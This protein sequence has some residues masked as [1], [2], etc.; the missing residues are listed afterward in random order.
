MKQQSTKIHNNPEPIDVY[1]LPRR[2][3]KEDQTHRISIVEVGRTDGSTINASGDKERVFMVVGATGAGKTTLIYIN[4]MAN[5]IYGVRW[6]SDFRFRLVDEDTAH[7]QAK[8]QTTWITAYKFHRE[9]QSPLTYDLMIIDTPG[10]GDTQG[11]ERDKQITAQI[12]ELFSCQGENGIDHIDGIG[13][14]AQASLARLTHSQKYIF[15]AILS[16]FGRDI[17]EIF[18]VMCTFVDRHKPPILAAM[19][20]AKLPTFDKLDK[21]FFRFFCPFCFKLCQGRN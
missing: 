5:Y 15:D 11:I 21:S 18:F 20:E 12:K 14:V 19:E 17:G 16:I 9:P 7:S 13:F 8:S 6:E 3:L 2:V 4:G 1:Q 10:F